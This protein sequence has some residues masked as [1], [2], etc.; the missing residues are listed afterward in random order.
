LIDD[1]KY[2]VYDAVIVA[3]RLWKFT[4]SWHC[5]PCSYFNRRQN[6]PA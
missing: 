1:I 3:D 4:W 6:L 5:D 2:N